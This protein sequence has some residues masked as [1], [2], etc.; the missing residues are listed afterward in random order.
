MLINWY[1]SI[2][3]GEGYS[4]AS[5]NIVTS[6]TSKGIDVRVLSVSKVIR[7][8]LTDKGKLAIDAPFKMGDV[9]IA[10]GFPN[11]FNSIMNRVKI[12]FTMFETNK[13]PNGKGY[14]NEGNSWAGITG[15]SKDM[16][17]TLNELWTPS[18]HN[19]ELFLKSGVTVPV[20]I[21][22]LGVNPELFFDFSKEREARRANRPFTFLI[23]GTL[24]S[25]K[26]VGAVITAFM[27]LFTGN[28]DVRLIVK[29]KSGTMASMEFPKGVNIQ[30]IDRNS[31]ITELQEYYMN[32][33]CFVF[34][35]RGEGFGLPP[36]EAMATGLPTI[37][38]NNTGMSEYCNDEYNYPLNDYELVPA[39]RF[40][41]KWGDVGTWF[42]PSYTELKE[43]MFEV[44]NNQDKARE[45][46]KKAS[47]WVAKNWTYSNTASKI[48][49]RLKVLI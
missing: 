20:H 32:A 49:E 18:R 10:F 15:D 34:P 42:E 46:G 4:G 41:K 5:E 26:N 27:E 11:S 13:L 23:L 19:R 38:A 44:Y 14:R 16:I 6:L 40:P 33:D 12:G 45:K 30:I 1:A 35:S 25:R 39:S 47:V 22:P 17:N 24:T 21:M 7:E 2:G 37:V 8:N 31:T 29:S 9:G 43:K 36:L 28:D 48:I 3:Q